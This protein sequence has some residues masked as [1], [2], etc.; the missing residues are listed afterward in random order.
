MNLNGP[1]TAVLIPYR[2]DGA[3]RDAALTFV[4]ERYVPTG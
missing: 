2:G 1:D 3:E 4:L